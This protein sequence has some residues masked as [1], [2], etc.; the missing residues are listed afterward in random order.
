MPDSVNPSC[1][2]FL[3]HVREGSGS[4]LHRKT[5]NVLNSPK[6]ILLFT[7]IRDSR[8]AVCEMDYEWYVIRLNSR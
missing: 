5:A 1:S 6:T 3:Q 7:P 8:Q 2:V 4:P